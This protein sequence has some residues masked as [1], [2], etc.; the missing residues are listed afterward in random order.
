M[1]HSHRAQRT[2]D[3]TGCKGLWAVAGSGTTGR[4]EMGEYCIVLMAGSKTLY[5]LY[6]MFSGGLEFESIIVQLRV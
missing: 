4:S 5:N 6:T 2:G 1:I 3:R